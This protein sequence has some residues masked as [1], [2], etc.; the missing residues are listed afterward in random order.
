MHV[1]ARNHAPRR[2]GRMKAASRMNSEYIDQNHE[3]TPPE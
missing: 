3:L 1:T 2:V